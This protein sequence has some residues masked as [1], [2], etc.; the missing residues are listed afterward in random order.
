[1]HCV[2]GDKNLSIN[3]SNWG[4]KG[5]ILEVKSSRFCDFIDYM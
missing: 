1:M 3:T 5:Y 2:G 4:N